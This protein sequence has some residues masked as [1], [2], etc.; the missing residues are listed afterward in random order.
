MAKQIRYGMVGGGLNAFIGE[1]HRKALNF[2][3]RAELVA[4]SFSSHA[5]RN[6]A[7]GEAYCLDP[8]RV[9]ASYEEMA[10]AEAAREDGIDFVSVVTPNN[11]HYPVCKAFL[12]AGIN[13]VCEKPLCFTV[14][15]AEELCRLS[16]EKGL[17]FGVTY[18][19]TGYTMAKVMKEMI[20]GGKIGKVVA[21]NA[22]YAQDWLLGELATGN[23]T[24]TNI[25]VWRTDPAM[26]GAANCVG[27]IGTHVE[28]F[29]HYVT[30]LKIKR[31]LATT[32]T[33]GKALDLNANVLVEYENGA[34]GAYWCSQVAAGHY[35]GLVAR[36][37]GD[38]GALEWV[39]EDPEH[40]RYTPVD[41]P[42]QVLARGTGCVKE[43]AAATGRLPSGHPEGIYVAF[44]NIYRNYV[45]AL[46]A[47]KNG[48]DAAGYDFPTV[49]DGV[50]GVRFIQA[51]V[52]SAASNAAWVE[53]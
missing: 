15:Q 17:L 7:T 11:M 27:D 35:N 43:K 16:R 33:Y 32:N 25:A 50:S 3:T 36:V 14:A 53:L 20:A 37:Y 2:D 30:G 13:V 26:S 49:E 6:A 31:L 18:T 48:E 22:E 5:D 45:S 1:V 40:L 4:G 41:G 9:Y 8:A 47:R 52:D 19:Y 12:E 46:I 44:A 10:K 51:V 23:N 24:Q 39:Q 21:V 29:I 42:T 34:N 28:N 38:K